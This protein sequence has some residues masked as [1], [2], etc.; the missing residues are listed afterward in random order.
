MADV[1]ALAGRTV[2]FDTNIIVYA[3]EGF[4]DYR[5]FLTALFQLVDAGATAAVTSELTRAM[6]NVGG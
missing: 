1:A 2:Y 5:E 3:V 6:V 4:N